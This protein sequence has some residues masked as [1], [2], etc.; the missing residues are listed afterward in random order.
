[1]KTFRQ[2]C[3]ENGLNEGLWL[4]DD[5]AEESGPSVRAMRKSKRKQVQSTPAGMPGGMPGQMP[6]GAGAVPP[7]GGAGKM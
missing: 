4:N 7:Q 5:R 2:W 3:Q 1:M 6:G